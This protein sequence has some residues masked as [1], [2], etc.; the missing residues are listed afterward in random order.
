MAISQSA[1][2]TPEEREFFSMVNLS[3]LANPFGDER[4][5]NDL[6]IAGLFPG[7]SD[8]ERLRKTIAEVSERIDFSEKQ[9]RADIRKYSGKDRLLVEHALLFDVFHR[10]LDLF[11]R[12]ITDQLQAGDSPLKVPF[13]SEAIAL[14]R[15]RGFSEEVGLR[16]FAICFQLRRAFFFIETNLVGRSPA[17]KRLRK[18]LWNNVFTHNLDMY[19]RF[20]WNR[21]EDFSTLLL[22]ETGTGKGTAAAAIGQ[23]GYIPFDEKKL[24][25]TESFSRS[26]VSLNLSQFP[27]TIIESELFGHKKGAFTGA[28]ED[29]KGV[30]DRCSSFGAIFLDEIGEVS[31]PVQIKL[32]QVIQ[33]RWFTPVGSHE[34]RRFRG[35]VIAA[36]NRSADD[37]RAKGLMRD[38]FYYRLCSDVIIVPPLRQRIREDTG[39]LDD[40]LSHTLVRILGASSSELTDMIKSAIIKYPGKDYHWPGNVRELEQFV[41][42]ILLDPDMSEVSMVGASDRGSQLKSGI[43]AGSLSAD[44][45]LGGYCRML[46][47]RYGTIEAVA[48]KTQLD[49]RTVKKHLNKTGI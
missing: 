12:L 40:L 20:L 21:M 15:Q 38:D 45:L 10:Y 28:V 43:D 14:L 29:F 6:R 44:E 1:R 49:R 2:L 8:E 33:E 7:A 9:G 11:D 36:T 13:A 16:Y 23:S 41:R 22:G 42:R 27:E 31:V 35:R 3:A 17:M 48:R 18:Q 5:E 30:F 37:L 47:E 39:E 19:D 26:F 46:Y 24:Q 32:L 4:I 34:K 25:F